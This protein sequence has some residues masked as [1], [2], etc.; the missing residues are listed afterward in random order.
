MKGGLGILFGVE[1]N[2]EGDPDAVNSVPIDERIA[3]LAAEISQGPGGQGLELTSGL[4]RQAPKMVVEQML[5]AE[6]HERLGGGRY[7]RRAAVA[8]DTGD[9]SGC[10]PS[11]GYRDSHGPLLGLARDLVRD[12]HST[13]RRDWGGRTPGECR[14]G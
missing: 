14:T 11:T 8:A 12:G 1:P 13:D 2:E 6:V 10:P 7:E 5:E 3:K 9:A 4:V